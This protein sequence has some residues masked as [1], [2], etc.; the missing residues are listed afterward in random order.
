MGS[1][2]HFMFADPERQR[3]AEFREGFWYAVHESTRH[4]A[5]EAMRILDPED[6]SGWPSAPA[7]VGCALRG[8]QTRR[9]PETH[10]GAYS[11]IDQ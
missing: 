9:S 3:R 5:L 6:P 10:L 11:E 4:A 1:D 8:W 7:P 2:M